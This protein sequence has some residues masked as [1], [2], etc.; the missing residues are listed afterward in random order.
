MNIVDRAIRKLTGQPAPLRG[1]VHKVSVVRGGEVSVVVRFG[2]D[3]PHARALNQGALLELA[4][5]KEADP[6]KPRRARA[7]KTTANGAAG[8]ETLPGVPPGAS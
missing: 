3:E 7:R 5:L 8:S 2:I 6:P 4:V 1:R